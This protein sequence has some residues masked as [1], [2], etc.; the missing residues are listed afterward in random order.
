MFKRILACLLSVVL[1]LSFFGC[2]QQDD[3]R[4]DITPNPTTEATTEATTEV[5]TEATT[6]PTT[7]ATTEPVAQ[8]EFNIGSSTGNTYC[9]EFIG[10][11]CTLDENWTFK[12]DE[13]M[14]AVNQVTLDL[15]G[16]EYK[17]A[18]AN[19][20]V[21]YDMMATH[22]NGMDSVNVVMEKLS[23]LNVLLTEERYMELSKDS[24]VNALAS[25]GLNIVSAQVV[26]VQLAGKEHTALAIEA[27]VGGIA[28]YEY[29]VVV[30]CNGYIACITAC[31][32]NGN[33]CM[34]I[35]NQFQ[36]Y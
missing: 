2:T 5:T 16:D 21:V 1:L 9:N 19:A 14:K 24:A 32:W 27:D 11:Q 30:K 3:I 35:L 18:L 20:T 17:N 23:G 29:M 13:E 25:M 28:M 10:I 22:T 36:A 8:Q 6:E 15:V 26:T 4:G 33:T 34:D 12:T 7:V 31:T